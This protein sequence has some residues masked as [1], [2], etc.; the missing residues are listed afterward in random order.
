MTRRGLRCWSPRPEARIR[1]ICLP[2][3]GGGASAFRA[4]DPLMPTGTEL[5]VAQYP[6]RED[7]YGEPLITDM[8]TLVAH[9]ADA[10]APLTDRAYAL[11]GH[12]MGSAVAWELAHALIDRRLPPPQR[13]FVS[14]RRAPDRAPTGDVHLRDDAGL[15]DELGRLGGTPGELLADPDVRAAVLRQ[16]RGDYRLIETYRP[17]ARAPL[18]CPVDLFTGD[19]DPEVGPEDLAGWAEST[20]HR[21]RVR[22]FP[23]GHFYLVPA[24]REVVAALAG[25]LGTTATTAAGPWPSTP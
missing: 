1:L 18:P 22:V 12:S 24:R 2:H 11:F 9:L 14:G 6:G 10:V 3:A 17:P 19:R 5:H 20:T 25:A 4:W 16:V 15:G 7:R 23:G 13:L 21:A 8:D